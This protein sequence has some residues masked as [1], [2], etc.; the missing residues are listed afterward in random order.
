[1]DY[2]CAL[3][4][5]MLLVIHISFIDVLMLEGSFIVLLICNIP[6][7]TQNA[8]A[9]STG[10]ISPETACYCLIKVLDDACEYE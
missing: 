9:G 2:I 8:I 10:I 3:M 6:A 5:A 4:L 7:G 1:M